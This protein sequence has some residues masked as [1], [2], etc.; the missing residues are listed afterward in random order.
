MN[1]NEMIKIFEL[2][3]ILI[4]VHDQDRF[5]EPHDQYES[6]H[7]LECRDG[8]WSLIM[9][10]QERSHAEKIEKTFSNKDEAIRY[11]C[12][13]ELKYKYFVTYLREIIY[14]EKIGTDAFTLQVLLELF[15]ELGIEDDL[16]GI[17][18][19]KEN[20][21]NILNIN[22]GKYIVQFLDGQ[23]EIILKTKELNLAGAL[24]V[25]FKWVYL[26]HIMKTHLVE[27]Q[28]IGLLE[29]GMSIEDYKILLA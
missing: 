16:Y 29:D 14:N 4:D 7:M 22:N 1:A 26:I 10:I 12:F 23:K 24:F 21:I 17:N 5:E 27:M 18:S 20:A 28:K 3:N 8:V 15:N 2:E 19:Y 6:F 11:F 9:Q 13:Y 25:M